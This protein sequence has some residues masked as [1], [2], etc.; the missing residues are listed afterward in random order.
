MYQVFLNF[1]KFHQVLSVPRYNLVNFK[2]KSWIFEIHIF[3]KYY[4]SAMTSNPHWY[5]L[6]DQVNIRMTNPQQHDCSVSFLTTN[7]CAI[8]WPICCDCCYLFAYL[9]ACVMSVMAQGLDLSNFSILNASV[10]YQYRTFDYDIYISQELT[11]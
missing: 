3:D 4:S 6:C 1:F 10:L 7:S 8:Y 5:K 2:V 9:N 11:Q